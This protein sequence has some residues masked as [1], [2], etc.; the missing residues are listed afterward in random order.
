MSWNKHR[1][2]SPLVSRSTL[3]NR[4][5]GGAHMIYYQATYSER[6]LFSFT[7]AVCRLFKTFA[8]RNV[9]HHSFLLVCSFFLDFPV[10]VWK[11][12][13]ISAFVYFFFIEKIQSSWESEKNLYSCQFERDIKTISP[14]KSYVLCP[15]QTYFKGRTTMAIGKHRGVVTFLIISFSV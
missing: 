10:W 9:F 8:F 3:A 11:T 15:T 1:T 14:R 13:R 2:I 4:T 12:D 6:I 5:R 7:P